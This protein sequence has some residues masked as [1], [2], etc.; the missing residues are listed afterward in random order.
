MNFHLEIFDSNLKQKQQKNERKIDTLF[1]Y[2]T[3]EV[4][5][6]GQK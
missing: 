1:F 4:G 2:T 5:E 3:C 6:K